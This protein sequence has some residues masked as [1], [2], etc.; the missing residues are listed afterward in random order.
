MAYL[1]LGIFI[2]QS[3]WYKVDDKT[4]YGAWIT[5]VGVAV[6]VAVNVI[7]VPL[8]GYIAAA[9]AHVACYLSM[10]I[11]SYFVGLKYYPIKYET[12]KIFLYIVLAVALLVVSMLL[13]GENK[14]VNIAVDTLLLLIF[15]AVAEI[16]DKF[17]T[18]LF[19]RG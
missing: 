6:T 9:W 10:V 18:L 19:K 13:E 16:K 1:L 5:F 11:V 14:I 7:F 4:I 3:I 15:F 12:G 2:N 8:F 17:F